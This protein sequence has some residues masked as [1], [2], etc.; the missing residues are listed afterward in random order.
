MQYLCENQPV[1]IFITLFKLWEN[2]LQEKIFEFKVLAL[3]A[4]VTF[5]TNVPLSHTSDAFICNF[6]CNSIT[7]AIKDSSDKLELKI[8]T[9]ALNVILEKYLPAK[10]DDLRAVISH[11]LTIL[12]AKKDDGFEEECSSLLNYL[13]VDMKDHLKESEDVIDFI[14]SVS[15][16]VIENTVCRTYIEF[17]QRLKMQ[18]LSLKYER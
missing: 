18:A 5:T 14:N 13:L 4:F 6:V 10:V 16:G 7:H 12:I 3:H 8:L 2:I 15:Q 1:A 9:K 11:L 17:S